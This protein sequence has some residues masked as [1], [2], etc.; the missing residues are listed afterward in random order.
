MVKGQRE[1]TRKSFVVAGLSPN[2]QYALYN[3]SFAA[4]KKAIYERVFYVKTSDGFGRPPVP[5]PGVFDARL[6]FMARQLK[7][8]ST[9]STPIT[10]EQFADSYGAPKREMYM[11]AAISLQ[12][13]PFHQKDAYIGAFT[14]CE[15]YLFSRHDVITKIPVPR[16]I[17]PRGPRALVTYGRYVKPIEP[18]IYAA[19]N[20]IFGETTIFKGLNA[21]DRGIALR[22]KWLKYTNPVAVGLDASRF[23]QHVSR[24]AL[25]WEHKIYTNY[26]PGDS[27]A[28][29]LFSLQ[30]KNKCFAR[31][32]NGTIKYK[33]NGCRMSGDM[34]T[35]LGNCLLMSSMIYA[36]L[37]FRGIN[38]S[39]ANDGD[40]CVVIMDSFDLDQFNVGLGG[41]F[42]EM[43]FNMVVEDPVYIFEKIVFCQSQ[44]VFDGVQYLMVRDPRLAIAKD[45]LAIKP[46]DNP[47]I[48]KSWCAAVGLGGMSLT[49]GIPVWQNFYQR[50]VLC[51]DGAKALEDPSMQTGMKML[52]KG[53]ARNH[54][55]VTE[56]CRFSFYLAFDIYPTEQIAM[57]EY[58]DNVSLEFGVDE[59]QL[60]RVVSLPIR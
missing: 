25:Q 32:A 17:Q 57:E 6:D 33:T 47:K 58:Y 23:D 41:W 12:T 24:A 52:A 51:S 55:P 39:L 56:E 43:G 45:C 29:W 1:K 15:K 30:E 10:A 11:K 18:K 3:N 5:V 28:R 48:W 4:L 59:D 13:K 19:I 31:H 20:D 14:K 40:D 46:L 7:R 54:Q 53:M 50:M 9:Y 21:A 26:Y 44:P 60:Q 8:R 49:G 42:C 37:K 27:F 22:G 38:A 16:I 2:V 36:Y 35:A 34:N